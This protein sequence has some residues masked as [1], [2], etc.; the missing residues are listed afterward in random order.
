MQAIIDG[1]AF[2]DGE[3]NDRVDAE[4]DGEEEINVMGPGWKWDSWQDIAEDE[5]IPR[6]EAVGLYNGPHG[7][8]PANSNKYARAQML[9]NNTIIFIGRKWRNITWADMV[10]FFGILLRISMEPM[11][12]N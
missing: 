10:C 1:S 5:D 2:L 12:M 9:S 7:L 11:R 4:S 6:P 3:T 8:R